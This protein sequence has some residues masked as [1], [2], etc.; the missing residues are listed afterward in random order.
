MTLTAPKQSRSQVLQPQAAVPLIFQFRHQLVSDGVS[1][2]A[3]P[4]PVI[5]MPRRDPG[6]P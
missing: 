1:E 2:T 4:P 3:E 5:G 6:T